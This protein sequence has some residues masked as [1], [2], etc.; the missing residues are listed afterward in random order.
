MK[1]QNEE[2]RPVVG[3]SG[4]QFIAATRGGEQ[5]KQPAKQKGNDLRTGK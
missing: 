4:S 3:R 5:A 1:K 2:H